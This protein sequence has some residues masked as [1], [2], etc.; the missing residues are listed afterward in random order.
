MPAPA[1]EAG[2]FDGTACLERLGA[3]EVGGVLL[4]AGSNREEARRQAQ[5]GG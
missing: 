1:Q 4:V 3:E 5:V 2:E